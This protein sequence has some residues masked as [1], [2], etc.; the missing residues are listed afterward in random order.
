[1]S[2]VGRSQRADVA[3]MI[4]AV[5]NDDRAIGAT[6]TLIGGKTAIPEAID[7]AAAS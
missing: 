7:F 3:A 5:L 1:M 2:A 6:W 4:A